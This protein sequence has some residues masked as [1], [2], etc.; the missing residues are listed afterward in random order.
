MLNASKCWCLP[1]ACGGVSKF[2]IGTAELRMSSS[3]VWG[4]SRLSE[5][6]LPG[7][8]DCA[9]KL[10]RHVPNRRTITIKPAGAGNRF[11]D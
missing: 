5:R 7:R 1:H 9:Q 10:Y 2:Q 3:Q 8:A 11:D 4:C 6:L